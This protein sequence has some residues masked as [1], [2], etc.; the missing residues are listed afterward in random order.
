MGFFL[1]GLSGAP[2]GQVYYTTLLHRC[3][4]DFASP[5]DLLGSP[6]QHVMCSDSADLPPT[7]CTS[8]MLA[9]PPQ[10]LQ[11]N[12]EVLPPADCIPQRPASNHHVRIK[13]YRSTC[14]DMP[15]LF[16]PPPVVPQAS[17]TPTLK[18]PKITRF[19]SSPQRL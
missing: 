12:E 2:K 16:S 19:S 5:A 1:G 13:G 9:S 18:A 17:S 11:R 6:F 15:H 10:Q 3:L 7:V 14:V 8:P 4:S